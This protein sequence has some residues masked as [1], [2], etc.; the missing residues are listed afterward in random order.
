MSF[1]A[2]MSRAQRDALAA[3][4][5]ALHARLGRPIRSSTAACLLTA[6]RVARNLG[7]TSVAAARSCR[8]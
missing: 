5:R 8:P 3:E 1:W 2:R 4:N 6:R 7:D